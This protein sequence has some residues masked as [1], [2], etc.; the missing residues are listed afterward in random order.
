MNQATGVPETIRHDH[1]DDLCHVAQRI[2]QAGH[3]VEFIK[4]GFKGAYRTVPLAPDQL[5]FAT[6]LVLDADN[7]RWVTTQQWALP[8]GAV[9]SVYGWE[10]LGHA[11][12]AILR[13]IGLPVLR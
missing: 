2:W 7:H 1:I 11:V 9:A 8:F 6:L 12:T 10:R 3:N 13:G 5:D 4:A